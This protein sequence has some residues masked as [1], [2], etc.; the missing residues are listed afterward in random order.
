MMIGVVCHHSACCKQ[1]RCQNCSELCQTQPMPTEGSTFGSGYIASELV[2]GIGGGCKNKDFLGRRP[3]F[4]PS[5]SMANSA[6]SS[7]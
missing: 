4:E 1:G 3:S 2:P 6:M 5:A 7:R